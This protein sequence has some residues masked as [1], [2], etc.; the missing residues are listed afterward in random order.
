MKRRAASLAMT[1]MEERGERGQSKS[2]G[3]WTEK[4]AARLW[5]AKVVRR[6][7]SKWRGEVS[8][9]EVESY[10]ATSWC[11]QNEGDEAYK[12]RGGRRWV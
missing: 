1:A 10:E 12:M 2:W 4:S 7:R 9:N 3:N 11:A 8:R 5:V 6:P